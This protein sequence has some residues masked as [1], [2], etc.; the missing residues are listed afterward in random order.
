MN[1]SIKTTSDFDK[2][3]KKLAKKYASFKSDFA[4]FLTE[5]KSNP[6]QGNEL[7]LGIKKSECR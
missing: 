3:A 1:F 6:L 7:Y 5:I 4:D 2:A